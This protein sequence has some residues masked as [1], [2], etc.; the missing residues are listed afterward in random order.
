MSVIAGYEF[1]LDWG[2]DKSPEWTQLHGSGG[3]LGN[4][5]LHVQDNAGSWRIAA[6]L[7]TKARRELER[8]GT[9]RRSNCAKHDEP[10]KVEEITP[11]AILRARPFYA[12]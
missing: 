7:L 9:V 2:P 10:L 11:R 8:D 4:G 5:A 6:F 1:L 3:A 12:K